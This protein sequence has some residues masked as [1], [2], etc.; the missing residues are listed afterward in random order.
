MIPKIV[1]KKRGPAP[2]G[3]GLQ[4]GVRWHP[5]VVKAIDGWRLKQAEAPP[6]AEAIRILVQAGLASLAVDGLKR[7]KK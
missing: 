2:T 1:K 7:K 4:I 5:D 3:K 6:R